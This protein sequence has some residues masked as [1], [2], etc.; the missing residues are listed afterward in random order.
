[1]ADSELAVTPLRGGGYAAL[2]R[3]W[4]M[5]LTLIVSLSITGIL[6]RWVSVDSK[7]DAGQRFER[8]VEGIVESIESRL[9]AYELV[10]LGVRGLYHASQNVTRNE[11]KSYVAS[12]RLEENYPGIQGI[13]F[14]KW[15]TA[16]QRAEHVR[17]V[18]A[19]GFADYDVRPAG[20][21]EY[22]VPVT[23]IEPFSGRNLRAFGFDV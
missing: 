12:L 11:W 18:R 21:R 6:W 1:M 10:L 3:A 7:Q 14:A 9:K 22:L 20:V 2:R 19:E 23:Y 15:L 17:A 5:W 16:A 4:P 8:R 13:A